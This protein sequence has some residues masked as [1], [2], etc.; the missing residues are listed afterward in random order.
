MKKSINK[1][2]TEDN[3]GH[4]KTTLQY[5]FPNGDIILHNFHDGS[6]VVKNSDFVGTFTK[7]EMKEIYNYPRNPIN[8]Q[9]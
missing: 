3:M 2:L 4:F 8:K 9:S 7:E 1:K 5:V 6:C